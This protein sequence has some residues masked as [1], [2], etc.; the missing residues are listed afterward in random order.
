M[1]FAIIGLGYISD[2][3]LE[4]IQSHGELIYACDVHDNVGHL[5]RY[6]PDCKFTT[7]PEQ[8]FT[9]IRSGVDYTVICTP[10]H[11]HYHHMEL[12]S[13][14]TKVICEKPLVISAEQYY[15]LK[16]KDRIFPLL[17]L[18]LCEELVNHCKNADELIINYH[19]KRGDWYNR[20]W[21][22]NQDKSGGLLFNIGIHL[23]DLCCFL[24][25]KPVRVTPRKILFKGTTVQF[26]IGL[27]KNKREFIADGKP[28][29]AEIGNLHAD[30]YERIIKGKWYNGQTTKEAILLAERL[31]IRDDCLVV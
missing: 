28:F 8:F 15:K 11:L 31:S 10:N 23:L 3:H 9:W 27:T 25:G 12:A 22:T 21:K 29:V 6:F 19:C 13:P 5:D 2:K 1:K 30:V 16:N 24:Y 18:R 17:Q 26:D 4:A 7:N 20:S 14:Y